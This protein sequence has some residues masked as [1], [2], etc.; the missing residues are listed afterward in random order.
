[1]QIKTL[2]ITMMAGMLLLASCKKGSSEPAQPTP[3]KFE[4]LTADATE[5]VYSINPSTKITAVATGDGLKYYW[6]ASAGD[7]LG[8]GDRV[9]YTANPGCCG[10]ANTI[11][12]KV[13]DKYSNVDAKQVSINVRN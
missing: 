6:S 3:F 8:S 4:S 5:I 11:T 1:M 12:C 9:T 13:K 2:F 7:I 10:G